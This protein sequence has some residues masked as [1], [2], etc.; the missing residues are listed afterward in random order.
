M[1]E[2]IDIAYCNAAIEALLSANKT[3]LGTAIAEAVNPSHV[4]CK[5]DTLGLDRGPENA[6]TQEFSG[7]DSRAIII[8]EEVG[9]FANPLLGQGFGNVSG[10]RTFIGCDP[11]DRSKNARAFI[12]EHS[13][14]RQYVSDLV[15]GE[16][17]V[18]HLWEA[19]YGAPASVTGFSGAAT[20]VRRGVPIGT[21]MFNYLT[22]QIFL[23][24]QAGFF[25]ASVTTDNQSAISVAYLRQHGTPITFPN[26][27]NQDFRRIVTFLGKPERGYPQNFSAINLVNDTELSQC[28]HDREAGGP[29]RV[30]YLSSLY[31]NANPDQQIGIIVANGEKFGEWLHWLSPVR[32]CARTDDPSDPALRIFEVS[33][34]QSP[35][36]DGY[37]MMPSPIYSAFCRVDDRDPRVT[38][39]VERLQG[40]DNPS[41][42][43]ATLLLVPATNKWAISRIQQYGYRELIFP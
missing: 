24:C 30:L 28:L 39:D 13:Q 36:R 26:I 18:V 23:C 2:G 7:F 29:L 40:L 37:L 4:W 11:F 32:F 20:I 6:I 43:R 38:F 34:D 9:E 12:Q 8:S 41:R 22:Q 21:V 10:A 31:A 25:Y 3:L 1:L 42:Y 35:M 19:K 27:T 15:L 17:N 14:G 5:G 33:Q 16:P